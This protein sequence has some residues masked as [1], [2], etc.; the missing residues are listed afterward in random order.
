VSIT[1]EGVWTRKTKW[2]ALA[3]SLSVAGAGVAFFKP[4]MESATV[5]KPADKPQTI[6]NVANKI[7][8]LKKSWRE[9]VE[10]K[11]TTDY[12]AAN[13]A[14]LLKN[15]EIYP[16]IAD[17]LGQ[18]LAASREKAGTD[19]LSS[20]T[21]V[22]FNTD[23][24]AP[25]VPVDATGQPIPGGETPAGPIAV[26]ARIQCTLEFT[27]TTADPSHLDTDRFITSVMVKWLQDHADRA[28]V[29]YT[30]YVSP[31]ALDSKSDAPKAADAAAAP[32][33]SPP[34]MSDM[35]QGGG[36][37]LPGGGGLLNAP[38]PGVVAD[39]AAAAPP[40]PSGG[41]GALDT[42]APLPAAPS[43][44]EPGKTTVTYKLKFDAIIKSPDKPAEAKEGK[45]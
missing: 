40:S 25:V 41:G 28:P 22:S 3:A 9:N 8:G 44:S 5:T 27:M 12:R 16:F 17:D 34:V 14:L 36:G 1:R 4:L 32:G 37:R 35:S 39:S 6:K 29:P 31:T 33:A 18:L 10:N 43:T 15:R 19:K 2:F 13:V 21:F 45:S 24:I 11:F 20:P 38:P 7:Q 23:Y 42:I 26:G 30:L